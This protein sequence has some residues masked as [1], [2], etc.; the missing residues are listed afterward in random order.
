MFEH[1]SEDSI[2]NLIAGLNTAKDKRVHSNFAERILDYGTLEAMYRNDWVSG[3]VVDLPVQDAT[4]KWRQIVSESL[5]AEKLEEVKKSEQ[6]LGFRRAIREAMLWARLYGGSAILLGVDD[7]ANVSEPLDPESIQPGALKYI[8]VF[9]RHDLHV[10]SVNTTDPHSEFFRKPETYTIAGSQIPVHASRMLIFDGRPLP[11]RIRERNDYWGESYVAHVYDAILHS[12]G[13]VSAIAA[14]PYK[15]V[16]DVISISGFFASIAA[17]GKSINDYIQRFQAADQIKSINNA[18]VID[19]DKEELG[20]QS[21]QFTGL[22]DIIQRFMNIVA[23][24]SD[25][26][27]TR[28]LGESAPGLNSAGQMELT[29]YYDSIS[30]LQESGLRDTLEKWDEIHVRSVL[31]EM[32]E[33]WQFYFEPLWQATE[34][35]QAQTELTRAQR[36]QTYLQNGVVLPS[37]VAN[38]LK[39]DGTYETLDTDFLE[40]IEEIDEEDQKDS[41]EAAKNKEEPEAPEQGNEEPE[42]PENPEQENEEPEE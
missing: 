41:L 18:L 6:K 31:G 25:I 12:Q 20:Q 26:P 34:L 7:R 4:R 21:I 8:H 3:K 39:L 11:W 23:A 27:A 13:T 29:N 17:G 16:V 42:V 10:A 15:A 33:D 14:L 9:D 32:P 40:V 2:V 5:D 24:A 35:E 22:S 30:D 28:F 37:H 36:D 1:F 38:Q 19:K